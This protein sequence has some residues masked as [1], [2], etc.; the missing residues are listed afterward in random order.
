MTRQ[1][2]WYKDRIAKGLCRNCGKPRG[3]TGTKSRCRLC[4][5]KWNTYQREGS[6][7]EFEVT[8]STPGTILVQ[9]IQRSI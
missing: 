7:R 4:A 2:Q 8:V 9:R 6:P 3:K 5:D 1:Q